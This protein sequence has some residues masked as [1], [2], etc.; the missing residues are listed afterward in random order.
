ME[1][2][3][4]SPVSPAPTA[5]IHVQPTDAKENRAKIPSSAICQ[6]NNGNIPFGK[7]GCPLCQQSTMHYC[8]VCK[9]PVCNLYCSVSVDGD[10]LKRK[11]KDESRCTKP[12]RNIKSTQIKENR[13]ET[14]VSALC[15][16]NKRK[17]HE[18]EIETNNK[19]TKLKYSTKDL[20]PTDTNENQAE[21]PSSAICQPNKKYKPKIDDLD[22]LIRTLES[23]LSKTVAEKEELNKL[24]RIRNQRKSR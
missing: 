23:K 9:K 16:S 6:Q 17:E 19:K 15:Q 11:H 12:R 14:I 3:E 13:V 5:A 21:I 4:Q 10:D 24:K 8:Q 2:H 7:E 20:E 18:T 22:Y 1:F